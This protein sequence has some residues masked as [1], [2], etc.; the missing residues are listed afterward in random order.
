[1]YVPVRPWTPGQ[2]VGFTL[3]L[4][5][6]PGAG[7]S[8]PITANSTTDVTVMSAWMTLPDATT[9][10]EIRETVIN[11]QLYDMTPAWAGSVNGYTLFLTA[12][13][14][15]SQTRTVTATAPTRLTVSSP[16]ATQPDATTQYRLVAPAVFTTVT[17]TTK[18]WIMNEFAT[19]FTF[20][21][22]SGTGVGQTSVITSNTS[23]SLT[24]ATA[25]TTLPDATTVYEIRETVINDKLYDTTPSWSG[26]VVGSTVLLT[27]GTGAGQLRT[28]S[29][30]TTT[31]LTVSAVWTTNPDATTQYEVI[32][33]AEL[34]KL[35]D[36]SKSWA[37]NQFTPGYIVSILTGAGAG[38]T[39]N[40]VSNTNNV[41]TVDAPWMTLPNTTSTYEI[42]EAVINNKLYD[43][44]VPGW[45][46][47]LALNGSTVLLTGGRGAGQSNTIMAN[48]ATKL[49]LN[50][51]W[52]P[53]PDATTTYE[54]VAPA[55]FTKLYDTT[56]S[57]VVNQF[58]TGYVV[59]ILTGAGA[60]QTRPIVSN[61]NNVLTVS[62][63]W[64][65]L[66]NATSTYVIREAVTNDKLFDTTVP[67]WAPA[68]AC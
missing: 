26:S 43:A 38:Q 7:Q 62:A 39:R 4:T 50:S 51:A 12:G 45:V 27:G 10:Y 29:A 40:V 57:W 25:L 9:T 53:E 33:A 3:T 46:T 63:P 34:T 31:K 47:G 65:P 22:V 68:A 6:G 17:D 2:F 55:E 37:M 61:T 24:L 20:R 5:G 16:W 54:V 59:N 67:S 28:I 58:M 48:T 49:T 30:N 32:P 42:R 1:M 44:T 8:R 35:Y 66:P 64:S 52:A 19:A 41:V 23:N 56:K 18:S 60:G 13:T 36:T 11:N 21:I 15:A 14:G